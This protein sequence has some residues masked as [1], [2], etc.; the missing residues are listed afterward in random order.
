[1]FRFQALVLVSTHL[2]QDTYACVCVASKNHY[3]LALKGG[4]GE[5]R[6]ASFFTRPL[7]AFLAGVKNKTDEVQFSALQCNQLLTLNQRSSV[8]WCYCSFNVSCYF[9]PARVS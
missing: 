5:T 8:S 4:F 1:M 7:C 6:G 3:D 9:L 2:K